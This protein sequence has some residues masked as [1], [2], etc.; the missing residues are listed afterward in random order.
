[1]KSVRCM[2]LTVL[3]ASSVSCQ[4]EASFKSTFLSN[5]SGSAT[6]ELRD[7][8]EGKQILLHPG[9]KPDRDGWRVVDFEIC[10]GVSV[11]WSGD[12][13]LQIQFDDIEASYLSSYRHHGVDVTFCEKG[14]VECQAPPEK[15]LKVPGCY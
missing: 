11:F 2:A 8:G 14:G 1:M 10:S 15:V 6:V 12:S 3:A 9:D 13:D 4:N 5:P 7:L